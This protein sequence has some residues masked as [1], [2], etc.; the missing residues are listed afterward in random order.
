MVLGIAARTIDGVGDAKT[1]DAADNTLCLPR[2]DGVKVKRDDVAALNVRCL[3]LEAFQ[4]AADKAA[5][6]L[7][8]ALFLLR[9]C[10]VLLNGFICARRCAE[11]FDKFAPEILSA[12][13]LFRGAAPSDAD[14]YDAIV[15]QLI[16]SLSPSYSI[17]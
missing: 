14:M 9:Q 2:C 15:L 11:P 4:C 1:C 12:L 6:V 17:C 16:A 5:Y 7:E 3:A 10:V 8:P 13:P